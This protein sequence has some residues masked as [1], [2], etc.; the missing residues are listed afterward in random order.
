MIAFTG[1]NVSNLQNARWA[2]VNRTEYMGD[3]QWL[4]AHCPPYKHACLDPTQLEQLP[5][6]D[7]VA[8]ASLEE[9]VEFL[10]V[11]ESIVLEEEGPADACLPSDSEGV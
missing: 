11:D 9:C 1:P 5:T 6:A 7:G 2:H 10:P 4:Q 8:P 3:V